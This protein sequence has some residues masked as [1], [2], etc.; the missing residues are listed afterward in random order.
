MNKTALNALNEEKNEDVDKSIQDT[1]N[2][3][4]IKDNNWELDSLE[5]LTNFRDKL[6]MDL[7]NSVTWMTDASFEQLRY[8]NTELNKSIEDQKIY[9]KK[10]IKE[11]ISW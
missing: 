7:D 9:E 10:T 3:L 5:E 1:L 4:I 8:L 11:L 2:S 6:L